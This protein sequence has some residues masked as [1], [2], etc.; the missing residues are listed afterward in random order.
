M[1]NFVHYKDCVPVNLDFIE[2]ILLNHETVQQA[3]RGGSY[4]PVIDVKT[5]IL[6][7]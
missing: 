4:S 2:S 6:L 5:F 1:S 7:I 3:V